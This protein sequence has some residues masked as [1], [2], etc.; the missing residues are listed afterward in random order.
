MKSS[1]L[2][3]G[4]LAKAILSHPSSQWIIYALAAAIIIL[5][6]RVRGF[7]YRGTTAEFGRSAA[8]E[9]GR[10]ERPRTTHTKPGRP[11]HS[12][13]DATSG[14]ERDKTADHDRGEST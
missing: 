11:G 12:Q 6:I 8:V 2:T 5:A 13:P 9:V 4:A 14:R 10:E 3:F 7:D 1:K